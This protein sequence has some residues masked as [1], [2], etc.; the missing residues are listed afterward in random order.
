MALIRHN[1]NNNNTGC[2]QTN[3]DNE[4]RLSSYFEIRRGLD[5][6]IYRII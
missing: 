4:N 3:S 2:H 1:D 6:F 5:V